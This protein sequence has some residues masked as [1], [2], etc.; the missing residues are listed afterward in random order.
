MTVF[1]LFY[2]ATNGLGG[3]PE[4]SL[5]P[6]AGNPRYATAS[7]VVRFLRSAFM[8]IAEILFGIY[9]DVLNFVQASTKKI[10]SLTW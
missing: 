8:S 2:A 4:L 6:G 3:S 9:V 1:L 10:L 7:S 5:S